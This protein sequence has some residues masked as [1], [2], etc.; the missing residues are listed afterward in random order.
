MVR[1]EEVRK[2]TDE[3]RTKKRLIAITELTEWCEK[4]EKRI[5]EQAR[6]GS[7]SVHY[8]AYPR[9]W[10]IT[11]EEERITIASFFQ[12]YGY[13]VEFQGL[14]EFKISWK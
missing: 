4:C 6:M 8:D 12:T 5:I 3:A 14:Y 9:H 2:M 10:D 7:Y 11:T 13:S 1:A